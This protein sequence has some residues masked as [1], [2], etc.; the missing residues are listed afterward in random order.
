MILI[1]GCN[2]MLGKEFVKEYP[3]SLQIDLHNCDISDYAQLEK[4]DGDIDVIINCAAYTN[5]DGC[6]DEN[7]RQLV[8]AANIAGPMNLARFAKARNAKLIH[9]STDYVFSGET[10]NYKENDETFPI[11]YY[12][13]SKLKGELAVQEFCDNYLIVRIAWLFGRYGS[14]FISFVVNSLKQGKEIT[15]LDSNLGTPTYTGTLVKN[16]ELF[17]KEQGILHVTNL[18]DP[19]SWYAYGNAIALCGNFD[20]KLIVPISSIKQRATRPVNSVLDI[21][22]FNAIGENEHWIKVLENV[23]VNMNHSF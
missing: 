10:G 11:N 13:L 19:I 1:V 6:E 3:D 8:D 23:V 15:L 12:G 7:N 9:F 20:Q 21:S 14:N 17:K 2:G 5:V 16:L 4:I 22:K 18:G